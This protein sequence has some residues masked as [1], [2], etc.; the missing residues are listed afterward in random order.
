MDATRI[1]RPESEVRLAV[2]AVSRKVS[3][4][5]WPAAKP[6]GDIGVCGSASRVVLQA[7]T[8]AVITIAESTRT[9]HRAET[10]K[11]M[12]QPHR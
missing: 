6:E 4:L 3:E 10:P 11:P 2:S 12:T 1:V 8:A 7:D 9:A 5:A